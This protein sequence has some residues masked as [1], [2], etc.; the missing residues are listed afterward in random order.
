MRFGA[1]GSDAEKIGKYGT[2]FVPHSSGSEKFSRYLKIS[3]E[4]LL[5]F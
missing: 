1:S 4:L 5:L 3:L 2:F